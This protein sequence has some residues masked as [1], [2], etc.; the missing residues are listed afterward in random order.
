MIS[1]DNFFRRMSKASEP[2]ISPT[3]AITTF[4]NLTAM[5]SK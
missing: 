3:P 2:Q 5:D 4:L 1:L